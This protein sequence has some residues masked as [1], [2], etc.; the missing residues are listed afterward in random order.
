MGSSEPLTSRVSRRTSICRGKSSP[1]MNA[2]M[3]MMLPMISVVVSGTVCSAWSTSHQ[4][5][6]ETAKITA[7]TIGNTCLPVRSGLCCWPGAF[8]V[9]I[10]NAFG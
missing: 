4:S 1:A 3:R 8:S 10:P 9:V 6:A 7:A 2:R 5:P